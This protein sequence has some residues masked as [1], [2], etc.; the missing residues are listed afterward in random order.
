MRTQAMVLAGLLLAGGALAQQ[1]DVAVVRATFTAG[2]QPRLARAVALY[3]N[4]VTAA[5]KEYG[6]AHDVL[7]EE[8]VTAGK[9][10][11][12]KLAIFPYNTVYHKDE[13]AQVVKFVA[14]G[15]KLM[16]FY[17]IPPPVTKLLGIVKTRY[18]PVTYDGE[19]A[20]MEFAEDRPAGFPAQVHQRS[21]NCQAVEKLAEGSRALAMWHDKDG[22]DTGVPAVIV[23][24]DGVWVSHVLWASANTGE[25]RHLLL[26][27]LGHFVPGSWE[28]NVEGVLAGAVSAAGYESFEALKAATV[29]GKE[30]ARLAAS[31]EAKAAQSREML[32]RGEF[33]EAL[34]LATEVCSIVQ[35]AAA[36]KFGS[37]PYELRGAWMGFP[38]DGTDWEQIMSEL[39]AANFN[40]VFPLMCGPASAAYPSEYLP[41]IRKEDE[42]AACIEAAHRHG[43]EVHP[44][45]ANWQLLYASAET[46]KQLKEEGRLVV[47]LGQVR[48]EEET[49]QYLWSTRWMDPSDERNRELELNA[50][51]EMVQKYDVD[52]IHYDFMRYPARDYC[53]CDR[54]LR[55]FEAW[56]GVKVEKWP[57]D[58]WE[59]GKHLAVYRDWRRHLQTS[60]V[61]ETARRVREIDPGI[62]ISLAARASMTGSYESDA[63]DWVTWAHEGY[64]D[65]LCPM[66]YTSSVEVLRNKLEP[67]IAAIDGAIPVYAGLGV[68]PTRSS[69]PVN[70]SEQIKLARE[71]GADGFLLF[72]LTGFS[73]AMLP[74]LALGATSEA[75]SIEPHHVQPVAAD[76][77][78]PHG[79]EWA[80]ERTYAAGTTL[81]VR[82]RVAA[83]DEAEKMTLVALLM[84]AGGG[85]ARAVAGYRPDERPLERARLRPLKRVRLSLQPEAGVWQIILRGEVVMKD[86][87]RQEYYL[88]SR[89]LQVLSEE[90]AA[91]LLERM[92]PPEFETDKLHVG[93]LLGG[94]G[95]EGILEALGASDGL[96]VKAV[97]KLGAEFVEACEVLILPQLRRPA[98]VF[99]DE[100]V[101]GLQSFVKGGGGLLVTHDAV[102]MRHHPAIFGDVARGLAEP[103]RDTTFIAAREHEL[104]GGMKVGEEFSHSYYDHIPLAVGS[105]AIVVIRDVAGNPVLAC[106]QVG[107]GRYVACGMAI[108]LGSGDAE[109]RPAGG[110]LALLRNAVRWL[111]Q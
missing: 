80:A 8:Q 5:L 48:G 41:Q 66:D 57:D 13:M 20:V 55:K 78:Y 70:L 108:G 21:P 81:N 94:Y 67:Q 61:K 104:T 65:M 71:L 46:R 93:V 97:S 82:V 14:G 109:V 39:A 38:R 47:S 52:G 102:G 42:L 106:A 79:L 62:K 1:A 76:F 99:T 58:C 17:T 29:G 44:W 74:A 51:T 36:A 59:G 50:M 7:T 27:T 6:V 4:I 26:A 107:K 95:T 103:V 77:S 68:S 89:P 34:S 84:P 72:S 69:S 33:A 25:Q 83:V 3:C 15:G 96:E 37:R 43:I 56:A 92:K 91:A 64:L 110:E 49:G 85:E 90:T 86:G 2:E 30:A 16:W 19:Y 100:V 31:A 105:E 28:R 101:A 63:Q 10:A 88:R 24:D 87:G 18:R 54:C 45:R 12:Y 35:Q 32:G 11:G 75:V 53:Y 60:L 23:S 9:L 22:K 73:R 40:A 111:G 98:G